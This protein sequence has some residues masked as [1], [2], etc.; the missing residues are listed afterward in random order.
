VI[1]PFLSYEDLERFTAGMP[2]NESYRLVTLVVE[3]I[4]QQLEHGQQPMP[5]L[6]AIR[7]QWNHEHLHK[8]E[9]PASVNAD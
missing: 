9:E 2:R 5:D 8:L 7:A 4:V 3:K 1:G 6:A